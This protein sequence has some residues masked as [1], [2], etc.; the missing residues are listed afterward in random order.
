MGELRHATRAYLVE[1]HG[2]AA[3]L[4]RLNHL[5]AHL[6]PGEIATM[7]LV[8]V[9]VATGRCRLANAGHPPPLRVSGSRVSTVEGRVALLGVPTPHDAET[10]FTL[11][12]GET[13]V[14]VTD[15][16]IERRGHTFNEGME[17]L[18]AALVAGMSRD[19]GPVDLQALCDELLAGLGEETDDDV[20]LL[21]IR[22]GISAESVAAARPG[23]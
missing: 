9:D 17:R 19:P 4:D 2:P 14:L 22:R 20:A 1:G 12:E 13:L 8:A 15:G 10:A 21:V 23:R 7:C 18:R 6:I 16:L 5:L 3:V 11:A